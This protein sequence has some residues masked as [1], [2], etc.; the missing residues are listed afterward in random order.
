MK[1]QHKNIKQYNIKF[2]QNTK[3]KK[4]NWWVVLAKNP[5]LFLLFSHFHTQEKKTTL[6]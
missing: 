5:L 2:L 3:Q 1:L 4:I 6:D